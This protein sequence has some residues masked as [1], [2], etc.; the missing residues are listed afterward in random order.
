MFVVVVVGLRWIKGHG[1][2]LLVVVLCVLWVVIVNVVG[3][4]LL[5]A[6]A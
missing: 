5:V 2:W 3:V 1:W 4:M 6:V